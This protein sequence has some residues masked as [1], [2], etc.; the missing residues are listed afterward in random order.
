MK[1]V[2]KSALLSSMAVVI[3]VMGAFTA[4]VTFADQYTGITTNP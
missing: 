4:G 2:S 1:A 3:A